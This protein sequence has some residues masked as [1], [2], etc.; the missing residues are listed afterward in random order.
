M[1]HH[2]GA[3]LLLAAA[4]TAQVR[5]TA[6]ARLGES[7]NRCD[8]R[9]GR[10]RHSQASAN[11]RLSKTY[12]KSGFIVS[13]EFVRERRWLILRP[14]IARAITYRAEADNDAAGE[15]PDLDDET[16]ER[17]LAVNAGKDVWKESNL[18]FDAA[19]SN[20]SDESVRILQRADAV[21]VWKRR[22]GARA[23]YDRRRR[24]L[25][26]RETGASPA[27]GEEGPPG[28]EGALDLEGF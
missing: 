19:R 15:P 14:F 20:D 11:G 5:G 18:N 4:L 9:Y 10:P 26:L 1:K 2:V 28:G 24:E 22:D 3:L 6:Q 25:T 8:Q 21:R 7:E 16:I 27:E 13:V 12:Q 23:L 17:L